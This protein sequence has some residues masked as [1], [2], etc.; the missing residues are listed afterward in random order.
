MGSNVL[1]GVPLLRIL[2]ISYLFAP[3]NASGSIRVTKLAEFLVSHGYDVRVLT[4]D[5]LN[6]PTTLTTSFPYEYIVRTHS[7]NLDGWMQYVR[8]SAFARKRSI[9]LGVG[10]STQSRLRS[11][12][13]AY[14]AVV[15]FPDAQVFWAPFAITA[16]LRMFQS[17][18]PDIVFSS[19]LPFTA[20]LIGSQLSK[21]SG[22]AWIADYRDLFVGNPYQ[23]CP[24]WRT[25]LDRKLEF[26]I[27]KRAQLL[28]TVSSPLVSQLSTT[29]KK[30]VV[31]IR[32][33]F[34]PADLLPGV[35]SDSPRSCLR[36]LHTGIIYPGRRD[37]SPLFEAVMN[38]GLA[39]DI[40]IEFVGQDNRGIKE[41]SERYQIE[42]SVTIRDPVP[43]RESIRLQAGSDV[44][45]LCL[46]LILPIRVSLQVSSL[47][48]LQR[49]DQFFAL[50][51]QI[52]RQHE[53]LLTIIWAL[54]QVHLRPLL[55]PL[56]AGVT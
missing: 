34:D 36:I 45:L 27:L 43:Y 9:S 11:F 24:A 26:A 56:P 42:D 29:L 55:Q 12:A 48:M 28:T 16:G 1:C 10:S 38:A 7:V 8:R 18:L 22:A 33:G 30:E 4:C 2:L 31:E 35:P 6:Y 23:Q 15:G 37:P 17:W 5:R 49:E 20:H 44:L 25:W 53:R 32:N 46:V 3:F 41:L 13:S 40:A 39:K 52:M 50:D 21:V 54:L 14:R 19:A 51:R 47:N